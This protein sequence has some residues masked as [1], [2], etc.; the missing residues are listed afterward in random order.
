V[1]PVEG[2]EGPPVPRT[3]GRRRRPTTSLRSSLRCGV[4]SRARSARSRVPR[5]VAP[6]ALLRP[7]SRSHSPLSVPPMPA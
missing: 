1:A 5:R 2:S 4:R 7:S 6:R 3:V